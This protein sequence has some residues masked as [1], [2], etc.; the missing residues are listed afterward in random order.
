[1]PAFP[2]TCHKG[3]K[4]FRRNLQFKPQER[5]GR[6]NQLPRSYGTKRLAVYLAPFLGGVIAP[7]GAKADRH[8]PCSANSTP[9]RPANRVP[10]V[11]GHATHTANPQ[12]HFLMPGISCTVVLA[13]W[14]GP[15]C[16]KL[17]RPCRGWGRSAL[18]ATSG[19]FEISGHSVR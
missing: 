1:M 4:P 18:P 19:L 8:L 16:Q 5:S 14:E 12:I 13:S 15:T 10:P 3:F 7:P 11:P 6:S 2:T 17:F 9:Q